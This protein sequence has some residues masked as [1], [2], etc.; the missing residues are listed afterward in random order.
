VN[1]EDAPPRSGR[2]R[3]TK[4]EFVLVRHGNV[5]SSIFNV[6]RRLLVDS[7]AAPMNRARGSADVRLAV[8]RSN[9][10]SADPF[11]RSEQIIELHRDAH[12]QSPGG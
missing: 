9:F 10:A 8:H 2:Q 12:A 7:I 5:Q 11:V 6:F 4:I 1:V 3:T